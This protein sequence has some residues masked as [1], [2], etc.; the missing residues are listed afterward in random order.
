MGRRDAHA[1]N[2]QLIALGMPRDSKH[3]SRAADVH[4]NSFLS[5]YFI[6]R[7]TIHRFYIYSIVK[8]ALPYPLIL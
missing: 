2:S 1:P 5:S 3:I 6:L 8:L 7:P 4:S